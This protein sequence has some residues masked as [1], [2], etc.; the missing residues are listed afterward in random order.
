[1]NL[2]PQ[3]LDDFVGQP[4]VRRILAVLIA[5]ARKRSE[6]VPHSLMSGPPGLGKTT[7][8]RI[9]AT[10]MGGRLVE[11]VGSSIKA[12]ADLTQHLLHLKANDVL[13]VDEIH[14]IPRRIEETLYP[15][16]EDGM[17]SVEQRGFSDLMKQLGVAH[18]EKSVTTHRLPPFTLIGATTLQGLVSA[19]LRSRFRQILELQPYAP[20]ELQQIVS[21]TAAKLAFSLSD[22]L[23]LDIARRSRGTARVAI[24][25][26]LW[27]RDVVQGDGGVATAELLA[28]AF[29]MKGVDELGLTETDRSYLRY[30]IEAEDAVG[31]NTLAS[32]LGESVE[33]LT[34]SLEPYLLRQGF[35][36]RT[37]KGRLATAKCR[38]LLAEV[39]V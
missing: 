25:H 31:L 11:M 36:E 20:T 21:G 23:A 5:A 9:V 32:V 29:D 14:A 24:A 17:V 3:T 13:F 33:T 12:P 4:A 2:R 26:L 22:D 37:A 39:A 6:P 19:P 16:M 38:E 10:E 8:A 1:M 35:V 28:Q 27:F 15:A 30:L 7:I 34:E 18:S